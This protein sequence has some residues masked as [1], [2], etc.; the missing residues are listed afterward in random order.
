MLDVA[1]RRSL[2]VALRALGRAI[3]VDR[4]PGKLLLDDPFEHQIDGE[5]ADPLDAERVGF[6]KRSRDRCHVGQVLDS[7][8]PLHHRVVV[9]EIAIAKAAVPD[10]KMNDEPQEDDVGC[11]RPTARRLEASP[12]TRAKIQA[13]KERLQDHETRERGELLLFESEFGERL[14]VENDVCFTSFH[15]R[16]FFLW[17]LVSAMHPSKREAFRLSDI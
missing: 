12:Q 4:H 6:A 10:E 11:E 13:A 15:R 16:A 8:G 2:E 3:E 7:H 5:L 1:D 17:V 14:A 9:V